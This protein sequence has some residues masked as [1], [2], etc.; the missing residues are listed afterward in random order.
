MENIGYNGSCG[1]MQHPPNT[2]SSGQGFALRVCG[3][4]V[5]NRS[6]SRAGLARPP[7]L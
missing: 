7:C 5:S 2:G 6:G 1:I 3:G 4:F